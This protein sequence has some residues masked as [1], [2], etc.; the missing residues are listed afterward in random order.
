MTFLVDQLKVWSTFGT[1][2]VI[3]TLQTGFEAFY[4]VGGRVFNVIELKHSYWTILN[5][6]VQQ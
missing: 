3:T 4:T 5:A 2:V 1:G 6:L